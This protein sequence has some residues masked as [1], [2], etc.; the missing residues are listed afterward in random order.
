LATRL[1]D[2]FIPPKGVVLCVASTDSLSSAFK[3]LIDNNIQSAPVYDMKAQQYTS[4]VDLNDILAATLL[5]Y[6]QKAEGKKLAEL[7]LRYLK[8]SAKPDP[9]VATLLS[10]ENLFK[11]LQVR[12]IANLSTTNPFVPLPVGSSLLDC[13]KLMVERRLHRVPIVHKDGK[14]STLVSQS[15]LVQLLW[16]NRFIWEKEFGRLTM[17][18]LNLHNIIPHTA[19]GAALLTVADSKHA[20]DAFKLLA[21]KHISGVPVVND[22]NKLVASVSVQ[23]LKEIGTTAN[24]FSLI[25]KPVLEYVKHSHCHQQQQNAP[26]A[27]QL[28]VLLH[29]FSSLHTMHF[30][31]HGTFADTLEKLVKHR[32]HHIYYVDKHHQLFGV[33]TLVDILKF[34]VEH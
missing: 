25:Q 29:M 21:D 1:V 28:P 8:D 23:D 4:L 10:T 18:E 32:A 24:K 34:F 3:L 19:K 12:D 14:L 11:T 33:V 27:A 9:D 17:T 30:Q 26:A 5:M 2:D 16:Q 20:I 15:S 31:G 13:A 22:D 7:M 6:E